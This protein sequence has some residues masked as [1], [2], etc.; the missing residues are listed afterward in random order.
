MKNQA[1]IPPN[2]EIEVGTTVQWKNLD[3]LV[4]TVTAVDKSFDSGI[5]AA[6]G[7][8]S[9]TFTKPGTYPVFCLAH[10]FMKATI[11]VK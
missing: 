4:H 8:Y 7:S 6:D 3:A 10:P 2:L 1:Y 9:H 5:I 11:T